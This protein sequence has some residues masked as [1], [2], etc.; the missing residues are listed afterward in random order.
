MQIETDQ[1]ASE[2]K[3]VVAVRN[4]TITHVTD[5]DQR[6]VELRVI[7][8]SGKTI[9]VQQPGTG[10]VLP[11]GPYML[12]VNRSVNGCVKPSKSAQVSASGGGVI[13]PT[14]GCLA[15]RSSIGAK[16]VGRVRLG[17]TRGKLLSEK[18]L[19]RVGPLKKSSKIY[20]YCVKKTSKRRVTAVFGKKSK[21]ELIVS[22]AAGHGN[23]KIR[24]GVKSSKLRKAFPGAKKIGKGL[25]RAS[26]KSPRIIGT[27]KGKVR[28]VGVATKSALRSKR[29]MRIYLKRAGL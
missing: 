25:Y 26:G 27:R 18:S 11:P 2:I 15:K 9:Q 19:A 6:T 24:P 7:S 16:N 20:R 8:R 3:N 21:V 10:N 28:F 12:F 17:R 4:P 1:P 29:N 22:T 14:S 23:R 13:N 5:G